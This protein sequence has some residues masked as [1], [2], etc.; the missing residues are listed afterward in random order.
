MDWIPLS[1]RDRLL[2]AIK[3]E[4]SAGPFPGISII[5][6][7]PIPSALDASVNGF[8]SVAPRA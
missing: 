6:E 7:E 1:G 5:P 4:P 2:S 3:P 8:P